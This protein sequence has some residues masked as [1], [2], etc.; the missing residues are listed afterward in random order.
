MKGK[1]FE[2]ITLYRLKDHEKR[3][4]CTAGRYGVQATMRKDEQGVP[5]WA[6]VSS[7]PDF[8]GILAPYGRQF[9]FEAKVCGQASLTIDDEKFKA[10]QL[11]HLMTR[12]RFGGISFVLIHWSERRLKTRTDPPVTWAFPV[13]PDHEFWVAVDRREIKSITRPHCEEYGVLVPWNTLP[14]GR[15]PRPDILSAVLQLANLDR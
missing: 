5:R 13:H 8:E 10:R 4:D 2:E 9:C 12:A 1:E 14:G 3:G 6:P 11:R 7:L 15:T